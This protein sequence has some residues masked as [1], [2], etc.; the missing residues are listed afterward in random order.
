MVGAKE[1]SGAGGWRGGRFEVKWSLSVVMGLGWLLGLLGLELG[2][3][4]LELMLLME[5]LTAL[6]W[7]IG[8]GRIEIGLVAVVVVVCCCCCCPDWFWFVV[9][10]GGATTFI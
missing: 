10:V 1:R 3:F 4:G 8:T 6:C 7:G 9:V 2:L 5:V